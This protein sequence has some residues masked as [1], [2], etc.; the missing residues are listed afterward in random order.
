[1]D[2]LLEPDEED[3]HGQLIGFNQANGEFNLER[4]YV[5]SGEL[6]GF[7]ANNLV[8]ESEKRYGKKDE[9]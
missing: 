1:L 7:A 2:W 4:H 8:D 6:S 5:D 9:A 3:S